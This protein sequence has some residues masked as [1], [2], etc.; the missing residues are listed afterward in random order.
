[1]VGALLFLA[2]VAAQPS[3]EALRLGRE[4]AN[5]GTLATLLPKIEQQ[6]VGELISAHPELTASDQ[7]RLRATADQVFTDGRE[8]LLDGEARAYARNLSVQDLQV[9]AQF[10]RTAAAKRLQAVL[11]KVIE[12][13]MAAMQGLNFKADV[14]AAYCKD[15]GKL[16]AK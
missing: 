2:G 10:H 14:V 5:A 3:P 8:R 11:P 12:S 4:I 13:T 16:C 7:A 15:T 1:V 6:Q 9:I